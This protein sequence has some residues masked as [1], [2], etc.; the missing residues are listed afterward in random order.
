MGRRE[1]SID[2]DSGPVQRF[3][4]EL[5]R[6]REQAGSPSY[7][8]LAQRA[9]YSATALSEAAGGEHLP[10][11][12][13]A[14]AYV[15]ACGGDVA[16]WEERWRLSATGEGDDFPPYPGLQPFGRQDT[17]RF[18]GREDLVADLV[19]RV[20]RQRV[21]GVFGPSGSGKS[22]VIHAGLLPALDDWT[23]L[24]TTPATWRGGEAD[25]V[26]VDQFEELFTHVPDAA[27]RE[28]F[29]AS[30]LGGEH[31]V[32]LAVR[33][34]F[35]GHCAALPALVESLRDAQVLV[36]PMTDDDLRAAVE[37]P[38]ARAG[39]K[40]QPDMLAA[41]IADVRGRSGGLPLLAH[42]L[43]ETWRRRERGTLTLD[44]YRA[45]GGAAGAVAATAESTYAELSPRGQVVARA[46]LLRLVQ[47]YDDANDLRRR[48][49]LDEVLA[50]GKPTDTAH[51]VNVLANARLVVVADNVV[52]LAHEAVVRAWPRLREWIDEDRES[53]RLH[54]DFTTAAADWQSTD[55]D[56]G[57]LYRGARLAAMRELAG[58]IEWAVSSNELER[59]FL[60]AAVDEESAE[61]EAERR[62]ARRLRGLVKALAALAVVC[63]VVA[64]I[65]VVQSRSAVRERLVAESR[66]IAVQAQD[67]S[68]SWPDA[69][70]LLAVSA[71]RTSPTAEARG[72]LLSTAAYK[73]V[74]TVLKD[75]RGPVR[76]VAFNQD[77]T[78]FATAGDDHAVL[79]RATAAAD[80]AAVLA[81]HD[82]AVRALAFQP[83]TSV[84]ASAGDDR[85]I[86]LWDTRTRLPLRTVT[87][88]AGVRALVF[89]ADGRTAATASADGVVSLWRTEDWTR[90]GDVAHDLGEVNGLAVSDDG[91]VLAVAGAGGVLVVDHGVPRAFA[92]H[93][94]AVRTVALSHD[95]RTLASGGDDYQ[96]VLRVL[97]TGAKSGLRRH[98]GSVWSVQFD[99]SGTKVVSTSDDG[100]IR[101]W[102]VPNGGWLTGLITRT[103]PFHAAALSPD[104]SHF[105]AGGDENVSLW[106]VPLPPLTGHTSPPDGIALSPDGQVLA[107]GG[108]DRMILLWDREGRQVGR[109]DVPAHVTALAFRPDGGLVATDVEGTLALWRGDRLVRTWQGHQGGIT[110]L[111]LS[112]SGGQAATGGTDASVVVWDLDSAEPGR[113]LP[114]G[115]SGPVN[116]VAFVGSA[117]ASGGAD[118]RVLRWDPASGAVSVVRE[119]GPAVKSIAAVPHSSLLAV[120]DTGGEVALWDEGGEERTLVTGRGEVESIAVSPD[121]T[122]VAA[123][124]ND[125][126]ITVWHV[127]DGTHVA[128]LT[129][130]TGPVNAVVFD[131][132][133]DLASSGPDPRVI[134]WDLDPEEVMS[135]LCAAGPCR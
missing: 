64:S 49:P 55:R 108:R 96:V 113:T 60:R 11:L 107:T 104:G 56:P 134:R 51:V 6:L 79:L 3:A 82:G 35:L 100:S 15:R 94:A 93:D 2:P 135:R 5:R 43:L 10:S 77:G 24:T 58:R 19:E 42:A 133:N 80:A 76:A 126:L 34:D 28:A 31:R 101:W 75:H 8:S 45:S 68:A 114:T 48:A 102:S 99:A 98:V 16:E 14:L 27:E 9:H 39:L 20:R 117:L 109:I 115:H 132:A 95:G 97:A 32:V 66:Q 118:G 41:A 33:A 111:A 88:E 103:H 25:L 53:L 87:V 50:A 70:A 21:V 17:E 57:L 124:A 29:V 44:G 121:G 127:G 73:P 105:A 89:T 67:L 54:R 85:R 46:V 38:A 37:R 72:A 47:T 92:D 120:G 23:V 130:H 52:E 69:A 81:E 119:G 122:T 61:R 106:R 128:T 125:S 71:Y 84:L 131:P 22:S 86:V 90:T 4:W 123:A 65:A 110:S 83:G 30:L 112:P 63:L 74:R 1:R 36:G 40:V 18:F 13:V 91:A 59:E 26:V 7:R 62:G 116:A 78:V 129:G 12:A